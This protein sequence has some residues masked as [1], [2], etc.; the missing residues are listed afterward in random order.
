[1]IF[2]IAFLGIWVG[3]WTYKS[4]IFFFILSVLF[5]LYIV[6]RFKWKKV[7]LFSGFFLIGVG[8]TFIQFDLNQQTYH[9]IVI[10]SKDNYYLFSCGLE[11]FYIYEKN[12]DCEVGDVLKISGEKQIIDFEV[13]ESSF[14]FNEY[15]TDKGVKYQL[16][17][18]NKTEIFKSLIRFKKHKNNFLDKFDSN[19][20]DFINSLFFGSTI[21]GEFNQTLSNLHLYRF[22][23]VSGLYVYFILNVLIK[24]YSIKFKNKTA[25]LLAFLSLSPYLIFAIFKFSIFRICYLFILKWINKYILKKKFDYL[26]ILSISGLI[27]LMINRFLAYQD[28]FVLGYLMSLYTH[29]L[30]NSF[31]FLKS[32]HK[33][34][35]MYVSIWL[36]FIPFETNYYHEISLL[37]PLI[38]I[39]LSP[40]I[41]FISFLLT[42]CFY[43]VPLFGFV[44]STINCFKFLIDIFD[45]IPMNV[46]C[47]PM[48]IPLGFFYE[49]ILL[50]CLYILA[51]KFRPIFKLSFVP[52]FCLCM[53][54]FPFE[55]TFGSQI[56]F[57]NVGQG[58]STL[59]I[60]QKQ[61]IL[62]DTGGSLYQDIAK[63]TLIPFL[64]K[65]RIYSLDY[66]IVTH[67]DYDHNGA[68]ASL[69][70][71]FV[72]KKY[73]DHKK[74][75][76]LI[77]NDDFII[78]NLNIYASSDEMDDN[79]KS[80]VLYFAIKNTSFLLMGDTPKWV[81]NKIIKDNPQLNCDILKIGH[82][83]SNTS[84]SEY[85]ID[86]VRPKQAIISVGKHN[87]YGHPS[88]SVL[89]ILKA[90]DI[91]IRRTDI[92]STI[93]FIF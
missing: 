67:D 6:Y 66:V 68:F 10:E 79:D 73:I 34:I 61:T 11:K 56:H 52:I 35:L 90:Y 38:Q 76:P 19:N 55:K 23:T 4:P 40:A 46:H 84:T 50:S 39:I 63:K 58:D 54:F 31:S 42:L 75:F 71:N 1:M 87:N 44:N 5:A 12:N 22:S 30:N 80:L 48:S 82:H 93:S 36:F 49:M 9:G 17:I 51:I 28:G 21:K 65:K 72:V 64:K 53:Y 47:P 25:E 89:A 20:V 13:L 24:L 60:H 26:S 27:L 15:L 83:G 14:D 57:I 74:E 41:I 32:K 92:E 45:T 77:I 2:L 8:M 88:D 85:F 18:K 78:K 3:L 7:I 69:N 29:C 91:R 86:C 43:F 81:E 62:I 59:I 33:K 16:L 70:E 37:G